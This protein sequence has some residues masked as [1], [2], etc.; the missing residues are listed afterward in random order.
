MTLVKCLE[1]H[2]G[3]EDRRDEGGDQTD[4]KR[5][6]K[7]SD[8]TCTEV[9]EDYPSDDRREVGVKDSTEGIAIPI[10]DSTGHALAVA[11]L[12]LDTLID[13]HVS[14]HGHT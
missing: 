13:K 5:R 14:I 6:G 7:P 1:D 11:E 3:K 8:R 9:E 10:S 12:F 2:T 4:N